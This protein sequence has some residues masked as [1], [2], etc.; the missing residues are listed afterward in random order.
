M[1]Y[2]NANNNLKNNNMAIESGTI[3]SP[4]T[5]ELCEGPQ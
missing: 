4:Y 1:G 3:Y 2:L 5:A